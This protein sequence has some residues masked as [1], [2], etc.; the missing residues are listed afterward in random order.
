MYWAI[1]LGI[2]TGMRTMTGIA[3]LAWAAYFGFL[4]TLHGSWA[5]WVGTLP[6]VIVFTLLALG[7]YVVDTLPRTPDRTDF[8][9]VV[10]RV[11]FAILGGLIVAKALNQPAAG[12]VIFGSMGALIGTYAGFRARRWGSRRMGRDLPVALLES[13][14]ALGLAVAAAVHFYMEI[15]VML[16]NNAM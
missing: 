9:P 2:A 10:A 13:G 14:V 8:A 6:S 15:V 7:E 4:P 11:A 16:E 1:A 12:G 5:G 3:V